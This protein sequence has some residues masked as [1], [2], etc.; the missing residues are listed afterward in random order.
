MRQGPPLDILHQAADYPRMLAA[1]PSAFG[2]YLFREAVD[3][4]Q[5]LGAFLRI[6]RQRSNSTCYSPPAMWTYMVCR[7]IFP[8]PVNRFQQTCPALAKIPVESF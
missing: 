3:P 8:G 1:I 2:F 5:P 7:A 4:F 6:T